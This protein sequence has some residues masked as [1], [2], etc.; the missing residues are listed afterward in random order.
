MNSTSLNSF[1]CGLSLFH[2]FLIVVVI[3]SCLFITPASCGN[4]VN[5]V[6]DKDSYEKKERDKHDFHRYEDWGMDWS[7]ADMMQH[8]IDEGPR[9]EHRIVGD[10]CSYSKDCE[11]GCCLLDRTTKIRKCQPM[12]AWGQRCS[13][14]QIKGDLYVDAC[15]CLQG[16][17]CHSS[18]CIPK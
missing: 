12:A 5:D 1:V 3:P 17:S 13:L 2:L 9:R 7:D 18:I 10:I 14:G 6:F 11:S 4:N 8:P 15:P 16:Y